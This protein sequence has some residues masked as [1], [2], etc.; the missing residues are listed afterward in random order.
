MERVP[1]CGRL[2]PRIPPIPDT[3]ETRGH[4]DI[5]PHEPNL[6][7]RSARGKMFRTCLRSAGSSASSCRCIMTIMSRRIFMRYSG[8][9][10]LIEIETL[11]LLRGYL[12]PRALGLVV[13]W[14]AM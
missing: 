1:F 13:E 6:P 5:R 9:K 7:K 8:Q 10:A 12:S 3:I 2:I 4:D 14:A 11:A